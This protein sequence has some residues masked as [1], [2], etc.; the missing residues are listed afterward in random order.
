[1]SFLQ[2][3]GVALR[4]R[5]N[6]GLLGQLLEIKTHVAPDFPVLTFE[7][8]SNPEEV[9]TYAELFE[10][11]H[12]FAKA[13]VEAGI[14]KGDRFAVMMY[15]RP[16]MV[17][18]MAAAS[19]LGAVIVPVDPRSKGDKLAHQLKNS[20]SKALFL[21]S[22]LLGR[23]GEIEDRIKDV[24]IFAAE[25]PGATAT[26]D[27]SKFASIN[28]ILDAPFSHVKYR[29]VPL[30]S[31]MQIIYTSGTTG[32]PKG[33]V[34]ECYRFPVYGGILSRYYDYRDTD[35][36]YT[37]LSLTHGNA[38]AVNLGPA[39]YREIKGVFSVRFT[40]SRLWDVT[41]KHGVTSFSLLGGMASGIYNE[42]EK[43]NDGDNPVRQVVSAGMPRA[44]WEDF[45]RRFKLKVLEW[46]STVE[47]GGFA[48]KPVGKGPVG[49]FGKP[50][51]IFD[52]KVFDENDKECPPNVP[53]ELVARVRGMGAAVNYFDNPDASKKKTR[54]GWIRS[55]DVVH[56]DDDG[57]F[58]FD[59]RSGGGLRRSGDFIQPDTVEKAVGE[60]PDV[61]EVAVFGIPA[62]SGAP[63]ESDIVAAFSLFTGKQP[64]PAAI[65]E[66]AAK[67]LE[68]NSVPSYIMHMDQIP[69]TITEK[70]QE[71]FLKKSFEDN[72]DR[73]YKQ[74]DY[75]KK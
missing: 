21:T 45:E 53:G 51:I 62:K 48:R 41:R 54:G 50:I 70:P 15:N 49:S 65:F 33:V 31:P 44:V 73:V 58:Y 74:D 59:Y 17:H 35:I 8:A 1:M 23:A 71:R 38:Q 25:K 60:H 2:T 55:G 22:D 66:T 26:G 61:S 5:L 64:D 52:M 20:K 67:K 40:K 46:Y 36:L 9:Q 6:W 56:T 28:E 7:D 27:V 10:N 32:D 16:E 68:A 43:P 63:G 72:K 3:M 42:P 30:A 18:L 39:L 13:L 12:R 47:G 37:G 69:K 29:D 11:S 75:K 4:R 57:W 24:K 34:N 19:I 14:D